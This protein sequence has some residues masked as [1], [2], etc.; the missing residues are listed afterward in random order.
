MHVWVGDAAGQPGDIWSPSEPT[1]ADVITFTWNRAGFL[2]W[3]VDG[4]LNGHWLAPPAEYWPAGSTLW[5]DGRAIES[6][7]AGPDAE[8]NYT[9]QLGPFDGTPVEEVNFVFHHAD[10]TWSSPDHTIPIA[11]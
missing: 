5:A 2:H 4:S 3:G 9:L 1:A 11:P 7:L 10:G 6:P 8:G